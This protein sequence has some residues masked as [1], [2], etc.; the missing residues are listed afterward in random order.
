LW[1]QNRIYAFRI[2]AKSTSET[3]KSFQEEPTDRQRNCF[4]ILYVSSAPH[5]LEQTVYSLHAV[6]KGR[7]PLLFRSSEHILVIPHLDMLAVRWC[8]ASGTCLQKR[9]LQSGYSYPCSFIPT[10]IPGKFALG[11]VDMLTWWDSFSYVGFCGAVDFHF[12]ASLK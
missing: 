4:F 9:K 8:L 7:S 11:P 12:F 1:Q 5:V 2:D 6:T 10:C 3:A